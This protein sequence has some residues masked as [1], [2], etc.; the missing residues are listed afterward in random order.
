MTCFN[1][2]YNEMIFPTDLDFHGIN[3]SEMDPG[4]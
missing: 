3:I 4:P 1:L 2:D